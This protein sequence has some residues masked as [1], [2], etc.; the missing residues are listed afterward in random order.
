MKRVIVGLKWARELE[1]KPEGIPNGRSRGQKAY[2]VRYEKALAK[3]F[4]SARR[5]VWYEFED[6]N[7]PGC[8]QVDFL[9]ERASGL[10]I[11]ECKYTWTEAG[12]LE[13]EKLYLPVVQMARGKPTNGLVVVKNL[14]ENMGNVR[15][16]GD[17]DLA[18]A[19]AGVNRRVVWHWLGAN[20]PA[21]PSLRGSLS[22]RDIGLVDLRR[23]N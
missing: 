19:S 15:I 8:C 7:G 12:H 1:K 21:G 6:K 3:A 5:G 11:F 14:V 2:G 4:S 20:V 23:M 17:L 13:L 18:L 10:T 9:L 22:L 16:C